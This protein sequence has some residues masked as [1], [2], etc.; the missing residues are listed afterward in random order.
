MPAFWFYVLIPFP[1]FHGDVKQLLNSVITHFIDM[2]TEGKLTLLLSRYQPV[3]SVEPFASP[4]L[5]G[6]FL[7]RAHD[8]NSSCLAYGEA[9]YGA[10]S[11]DIYQHLLALGFLLI[12]LHI[13]SVS[14]V[15]IQ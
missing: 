7:P 9:G 10:L 2:K 14:P 8:P 1:E 6:P 3:W 4:F 13:L 15:R 5:Q 11:R 12:A